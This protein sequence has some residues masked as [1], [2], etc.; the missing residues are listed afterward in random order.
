[1]GAAGEEGGKQWEKEQQGVQRGVSEGEVGVEAGFP[2]HACC[3][4]TYT[5]KALVLFQRTSHTHTHTHTTHTH[6]HAHTHHTCGTTCRPAGMSPRCRV[7]AGVKPSSGGRPRRAHWKGSSSGRRA[8]GS[9][10]AGSSRRHSGE[11]TRWWVTCVV[12]GGKGRAGRVCFAVCVL[13][14]TPTYPSTHAIL[15]CRFA[16]PPSKRTPTLFT[17]APPHTHT[18]LPPTSHTHKNTDTETHLRLVLVHHLRQTKHRL[19]LHVIWSVAAGAGDTAEA[20]AEA[21]AR[22]GKCVLEVLAC[23]LGMDVWL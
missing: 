7:R 9:S 10:A 11:H 22:A 8:G 12:Q 5:C 1:M 13:P 16:P 6:A 23:C 14:P 2:L 15:L 21:E 18:R 20:G 19:R 4:H 17:I 3:T